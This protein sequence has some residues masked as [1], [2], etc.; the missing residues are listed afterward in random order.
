MFVYVKG[1]GKLKV[2]SC[3]KVFGRMERK[4]EKENL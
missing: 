1:F 3:M 2:V 4:K